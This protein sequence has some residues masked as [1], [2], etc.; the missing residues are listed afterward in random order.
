MQQDDCVVHDAP[1]NTKGSLLFCRTF[2]FIEGRFNRFK[3]PVT[4]FVP[5]KIINAGGSIIKAVAFK[6]FGHCL[7]DACK[8]G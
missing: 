1:Q 4:K 7:C 5:D 3:I 6:R 8:S 2:F